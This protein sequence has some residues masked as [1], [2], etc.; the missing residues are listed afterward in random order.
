MKIHNLFSTLSGVILAVLTVASVSCNKEDNSD[1]EEQI[2]M[3]NVAVTDFV[4]QPDS[5]VMEDLDS[6]Y[7]SIDLE[8][9]VIFN[10]DSLPKGTP[11]NKLVADINYSSLVT[12]ATITMSG[13]TTRTGEI[14]Y[15]ANPTDSIDFTGDVTLKLSYGTMTKSYKIKVNVHKEKA[16]SLVWDELKVRQLPS[17]LP[18][19]KA[20]KTI[21]YNDMAISLIEENDGS[22]TLSSSKNLFDDEWTKRAVTF[23]FTPDVRSICATA[24]AMYIL[25]SDGSLYE[26]TDG[27]S[28]TDTSEKWTKLLGAYTDTAIGIKT[29]QNELH[30]AQYP[31]KNL[32]TS[33]VDPDFPVSGYSNFVTLVNKWT[34][35][36]VA[37]FI[38]GKKA[39]GSLSNVTWAFDGANWI[40]LCEGG[41]PDIEGASIIPYYNFLYTSS[42]L[43]KTEFPVWM[44]LGGELEDGSFNRNVYISYDNGVTW[45]KGTSNLQLPEAIPAMIDCDN[46]VMTL[47]KNVN[48]SDI[49]TRAVADSAEVVGDKLYWDCPYI[50]L[51]G[52]LNKEGK[53]YNTIWR[54]V[55]ARLSFPPVI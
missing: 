42:N 28:W 34:S 9:G 53:L 20:Q 40:K 29:I 1:T 18:T 16:D 10:A 26:S 52:G 3:S 41:I 55:L 43:V 8:H 13:G 54:G 50:Y 24:K 33:T 48:L 2:V 15:D 22:F 32:V 38:G 51:F 49:W 37:F 30:Y 21:S 23:D 14:N 25:S 6:V 7:F 19:P 5:K 36:P 44:I 27:I 12:E 4:L 11:I 45:R 47:R 17:R 39:D 46:V 35:S 31:A